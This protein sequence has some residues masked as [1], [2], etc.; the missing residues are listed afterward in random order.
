MK[1]Y[2]A[3]A[4]GTFALVF[5]GTGAI[6]INDISGGTVTHLGIAL[7]F[8]LIILGMI[9]ALGDISGAHFN[10]AVTLGF[11]VAGEFPAKQ[12]VPYIIAQAIG[13]FLAS[14]LLKYLFPQNI[15]LGAT[16]PSGTDMQSFWLEIVL[17]Y[18]LM[19]VIIR[20]ATGS[21]ETGIMAGIAIGS[22]V[23]LEAAFAGPISG[24]SM[25]PIRSLAP[26]VISGDLHSLWIYL[27]APLIGSV[28]AILT[29]KL[30]KH[31]TST[32]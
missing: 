8:G 1:K 14:S 17:T 6:I 30:L 10:P 13:A 16:I 4:I 11:T 29:N 23:G 19:L 15:H 2:L 9:Y 27:T 28:L 26:A 18:F 24:A 21:K 31:S 5:C 32:P 12:I 7:T 25:N 3:E 20:V 22:I